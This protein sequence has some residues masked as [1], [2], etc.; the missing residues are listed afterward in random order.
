MSQQRYATDRRKKQAH[1]W[2][3]IHCL[4]GRRRRHRRLSDTANPYLTLDWHH[5]HLLYITLTILFLCFADA[6]NTLQLL[7]EGATEVNLF[8]DRLI[9]SSIT[10]FMTVKMGMTAVCLV[11]LVSYHQCVLLKRFRVRHMIYSV[12]GLYV[13]LI[14]YQLAIWPGT[15]IPFI[16]LPIADGHIATKVAL[17]HAH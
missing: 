6:H 16:L 5:P 9:H 15:G 2:R 10:L 8:M 11:L 17:L 4:R 12:L 1:P 13:G 14:A 3:N 7:A